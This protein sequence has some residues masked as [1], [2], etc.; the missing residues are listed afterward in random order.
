MSDFNPISVLLHAISLQGLTPLTPRQVERGIRVGLQT[1]GN[2]GLAL[3][4]RNRIGAAIREEGYRLANT[5]IDRAKRE[6]GFNVAALSMQRTIERDQTIPLDAIPITDEQIR[7]RY[8]YTVEMLRETG[9]P[10]EYEHI[11][12]FSFGSDVRL[13]PGQA[14]DAATDEILD[15]RG[16]VYGE[17]G[18]DQIRFESVWRK[19]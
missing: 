12:W 11:G 14:L 13:T 1:I 4:S 10:G 5:S 15:V 17:L 2:Q 8:K 9:I 19:G 18:V 7:N 16:A 6:A 3:P